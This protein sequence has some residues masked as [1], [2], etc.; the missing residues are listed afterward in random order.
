M[1]IYYR[2]LKK[3]SLDEMID[4]HK[5]TCDKDIALLE[6]DR[7]SAIKK[8]EQDNKL[9]EKFKFLLSLDEKTITKEQKDELFMVA[10][11][12]REK[13]LMLSQAF[14]INTNAYPVIDSIEVAKMYIEMAM[15]DLEPNKNERLINE[16]IERLEEEKKTNN[17]MFVVEKDDIFKDLESIKTTAVDLLEKGYNVTFCI[18]KAMVETKNDENANYIYSSQ[19]F[20]KIIELDKF[21]KTKGM[22][23]SIIFDEFSQFGPEE[24]YKSA[25]NFWTL[26][27]VILANEK[28]DSVV[29]FIKDNNLSPYEAMLFIHRYITS[30]FKYTEGKLGEASTIVGAYNNNKI[31]C[32]GYSSLTK[33]IIDKLGY[34]DLSCDFIS[35]GLYSKF[36]FKKLG[37][38]SQIVVH[39]KDEKYGIDGHYIN[40][41]CWDSKNDKHEKGRG[42]AHCMYSV[43]DLRHMNNIIYAGQTDDKDRGAGLIIDYTQIKK[44]RKNNHIKKKSPFATPEVV[45]KYGKKSTP[46][47]LDTT[48]KALGHVLKCLNPKY[49]D[50]SLKEK[51]INELITETEESAVHTFSRWSSNPYVQLAITNGNYKKFKHKKIKNLLKHNDK[52]ESEKQDEAASNLT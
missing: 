50:E 41:A 47:P 36:P 51:K 44:Y 24:D 52:S 7:E 37:S 13:F 21:L 14:N 34:K 30:V 17:I 11:M 40:D 45:K 6:K 9:L 16:E 5:K 42:F 33:A 1:K 43:N 20:E 28:V 26:E 49:E 12:Q 15:C 31:I 48:K 4:N 3:M 39:I 18:H 23:E 22:K 38:H 35:C 8:D 2:D 25:G 46:I 32:S 10:N 19:E 29:K 27:Q